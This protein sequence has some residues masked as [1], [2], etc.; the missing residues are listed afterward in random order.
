M[1]SKR[2]EADDLKGMKSVHHSTPLSAERRA[3]YARVDWPLCGHGKEPDCCQVM[4]ALEKG[5]V[6]ARCCG[7]RKRAKG[8]VV[9]PLPPSPILALS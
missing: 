3:V 5:E 4:H 1:E 7:G 6:S 9:A 2:G 8:N